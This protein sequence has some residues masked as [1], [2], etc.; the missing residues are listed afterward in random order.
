MA[1]SNSR[2]LPGQEWRSSARRARG[3]TPRI[4]LPYCCGKLLDKMARQ[5]RQILLRS[6]REGTRN[7]DHGETVVK[8]LAKQPVGDGL[9]QIA[10]VAAMT[11]TLTLRDWSEPTRWIS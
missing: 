6:A 11:R 3:E 1:F 9:A 10:C 4:V 2:T 8:V 7:L 5:Q